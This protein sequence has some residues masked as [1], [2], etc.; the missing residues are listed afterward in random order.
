MPTPA[1]AR[2]LVVG[3]GFAGLNAAAALQRAN[4]TFKV[5][6]SRSQAGGCWH[7]FY[8]FCHLHGPYMHFGVNG[9]P[10]PYVKA[11][12]ASRDEVLRHF[13]CYAQKVD[14]EGD[15]TFVAN[16]PQGALVRQ[17]N[18]ERLI[19]STQIIDATGFNYVGRTTTPGEISVAQ[20]SR[21]VETRRRHRRSY[22][23]AGGGKTGMDVA[24]YLAQRIQ[25]DDHLVV[26]QGSPKFFWTRDFILNPSRVPLSELILDALLAYDGKNAIDIFS[27]MERHGATCR[28]GDAAPTGMMFGIIS[29]AE[30]KLVE[31]SALIVG[32]DHLDTPVTEDNILRLRSGNTLPLRSGDEVVVVDA[33]GSVMA[34]RNAYSEDVHP[35]RAD[36]TLRY[37]SLLGFT[38]NTN[39]LMALLEARHGKQILRDLPLFGFK[40]STYHRECHDANTTLDFFCKVY[41]NFA[42]VSRYLDFNDIASYK[43]DVIGQHPLF[44]R[45]YAAARFRCKINQIKRQ[46]SRFL[47]PLNPCDHSP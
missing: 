44:R 39:Y 17:G 13:M 38:G 29:H 2:Y 6:D 27:H 22:V 46:A 47:R 24:C 33:R 26:I 32:H 40:K 45:I 41:V 30:R 14:F 28:V 11:Q 25:A 19:P 5:I 9:Q 15:T 7:D 43:L 36:G 8:D 37:G 1:A 34:A 10:W 3:G 20:L 42:A 4:R 16:V 31:D 12:L 21:I 23:V 35:M 18:E